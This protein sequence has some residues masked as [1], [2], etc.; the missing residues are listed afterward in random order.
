MSQTS[1]NTPAAK[2]KGAGVAVK[3]EITPASGSKGAVKGAAVAVK[4]EIK[5]A[6]KATIHPPPHPLP[7]AP[8]P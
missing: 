5:A 4:T 3:R 7:Q 1:G 6:G 8:W 2:G